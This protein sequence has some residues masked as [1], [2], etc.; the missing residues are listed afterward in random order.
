MQLH[1]DRVLCARCHPWLV[2]LS[3]A[4][5]SAG[6]THNHQPCDATI[7]GSQE[8]IRGRWRGAQVEE[9]RGAVGLPESSPHR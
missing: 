9:R 3:D 4:K 8:A 2:A 6:L 5:R 7:G 1:R